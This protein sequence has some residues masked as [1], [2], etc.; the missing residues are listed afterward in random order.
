MK[1]YCLN[2]IT[3][4]HEHILN[5][6]N[7]YFFLFIYYNICRDISQYMQFQLSKPKI[8]LSSELA[9]IILSF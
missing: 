5:L 1:L 7:L 2:A 6:C 4:L 8:E 3:N 9:L